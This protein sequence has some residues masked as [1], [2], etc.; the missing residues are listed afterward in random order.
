MD[1][2]ERKK[3]SHIYFL[4]VQKQAVK[5]QKRADML[6]R[7]KYILGLGDLFRFFIDDK[8]QKDRDFGNVI[9]KVN[10]MILKTKSNTGVYLQNG[11]RR[12]QGSEQDE[13]AGL[14]EEEENKDTQEEFSTTVFTESPGYIQGTLRNYQIQGLNW[15]V[16][17][18]ENSISGIL[19]DEMGL[20]KTLQIIS[21]IGYL[22]YLRKI[23]GPHLVIVPK[24]TLKNW[25]HE[26]A[27]WTP[28]IRT[29]LFQGNKNERA[30]L[31]KDRVLTC[32]FDVLIASYD[33]II[34]D[35]SVI[36]KFAWQYIIF[37][38]AQ[39]IKNETS[40]LSK[41]IRMF[42]SRHRLLITG[43]PLQNN[44]QELWALLNFILP[45][46]FFNSEKFNDWFKSNDSD[47]DTVVK[48]LHRWLNPFLLRRIKSDVEKSLLPKKETNLYV[49]MSEMQYKWYK[50]ILERNINAI[51]TLSS[52]SQHKS[53]LLNIFMQLR[54]CCNHPYLFDGAE[55]GPPYVIG[56]HIVQNSTKLA[57][58]D[59]LLKRF[60]AQGSR[61]LIFSQMKRMLDILEDYCV[62]RNFEFNRID[63]DTTYSSRVAAI[64]EYNRPGS[65]SFVFLLTTRSGGVG[66]NLASADTV[67]IY[68]SDWNPQVD[69]QAMDRAHRIGQTKQVHVY[70]FVTEN[71]VEEKILD[72]A[73]H[74]MRLDQLVIQQGRANATSSQNPD[75]T[76]L[77]DIIK[78]GAQD[79]LARNSNSFKTNTLENDN[80]K[81]HDDSSDEI[82]QILKRGE[83]KTK[84]LNSRYENLGLGDLQGSSQISGVYEWNGLVFNKNN[85]NNTDAPLLLSLGKRVRKPRYKRQDIYEFINS[86]EE[87]TVTNKTPDFFRK[88]ELYPMPD[89]CF[90]PLRFRE[91]HE[92]EIYWHFKKTNTQ[93][94]LPPI[95]SGKFNNVEECEAEKH[96]LQSLIDNAVP[97]TPTEIV[98][99]IELFKQ[100]F[101]NW[102][103]REFS[104]FVNL[105][106]KFGRNS[107]DK[108]AASLNGKTYEEVKQYAKVFWDRYKELTDY[109]KYLDRIESLEKRTTKI[110]NQKTVLRKKIESYTAPQ[111]QLEINIP[112]GSRYNKVFT[113]EEDRF[114]LVQLN[115]FGVDTPDIYKIIC[116]AIHASPLFRFNWF[117]LSRSRVQIA[118]RCQ[119]LLSNIVKEA[120]NKL[121]NEQDI[122]ISNTI[123]NNL[124][125]TE[126]AIPTQKR[127]E[128]EASALDNGLTYKKNKIL[129][130]VE[131]PST[132]LN[133]NV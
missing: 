93:A 13:D 27:K 11:N 65:K 49:R 126:T 102:N 6:V 41:V 115:R 108:I 1:S 113:E 52:G 29:L 59:K 89:F 30:Q 4:R 120:Q 66:I 46:V 82:E 38:E 56:E 95:I 72:R 129:D 78:F 32:D 58:L 79:I 9:Q 118:N 69:L 51:N 54:K 98:E 67:V 53:G 23:D 112:I 18:Y 122:P 22:K 76:E 73:A 60:Q 45:D 77:S 84:L 10:S 5:D 96:R 114:L 48:K 36:N 55:T 61:V 86:D 110:E 19:A 91:L 107:I 131:T 44:L 21:F 80:T 106:G 70:R 14:L 3:R 104:Q 85:D 128:M 47:Q 94:L 97:L 74:K 127:K 119:I 16:S 62:F 12:Q 90:F 125:T 83:E 50:S 34:R 130:T 39:R 68:D 2:N 111:Q 121:N 24:S 15:L 109:Q 8:V 101:G 103:Q 87:P 33:I 57:V 25:E 40:S 92:K 117:F 100:G 88:L 105:S 17:L 124:V 26:F 99:K 116:D 81:S 43:T 28:E 20:G 133:D 37:D 75:A 7:F 123:N 35:K 64:D 63:G 31:V 71:T 132:P 42:S